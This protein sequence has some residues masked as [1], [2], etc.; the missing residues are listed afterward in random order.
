VNYPKGGNTKDNVQSALRV[1]QSHG[2]I[3]TW[4]KTYDFEYLRPTQVE[5]ASFTRVKDNLFE[6]GKSVYVQTSQGL[7]RME[8]ALPGMTTYLGGLMCNNGRVFCR[9]YAIQPTPDAASL[10]YIDHYFYADDHH[11]YFLRNNMEEFHYHPELH[12][13][14]DA[15]PMNFRIMHAMQ[16]AVTSGDERHVWLNGEI[17]PGVLPDAVRLISPFFWTDGKRVYYHERLIPD[18]DP[19]T[20][21]VL[22]DSGYARQGATIYFC[23][24]KVPDADA[25]SFITDDWHDAHDKHRNYVGGLEERPLDMDSLGHIGRD[26]YV[27]D[28]HVFLLRNISKDGYSRLKL[29]ILQDADPANFWIVRTLPDD[30][31]SGDEQHVWLNGELLPG[32]LPDAVR[33][34]DSFF[35]TDGKYVYY[36]EKPVPDA[37]PETFEVLP[38]SDYARQGATVYFRASKVPGADATSLVADSTTAAHDQHQR[39]HFGVVYA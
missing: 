3:P 12:V 18:A 32:V 9:G 21:K 8:G 14:Q 6:D 11:V 13:L 26:F 25:A 22:P 15:E 17:L 5:G 20:F 30:T 29:H 39:Y 27:D 36:C 37:D 28:Y 24:S 23:A 38:D 7:I 19:E 10:R 16:N 34:M 4:E 35:W 31:I 2:G 33:F 1:I